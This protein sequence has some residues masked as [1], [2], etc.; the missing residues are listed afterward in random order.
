[1]KVKTIVWAVCAHL[2]FGLLVSCAS[3]REMKKKRSAATRNLGEVYLLKEQYSSA[4]R[5]FLK[6]EKFYA[7]DHILQND[8]GLTLRGMGKLELSLGYF[9]KAI[10]INPEYASAINN[11][12]TVYLAQKNWDAAIDCFKKVT[13]NLL[14]GTPHYPL[15]NL[16]QAYYFK[17]EYKLSEKYYLEALKIEPKFIKALQGLGLTYIAM[18][19]IAD[20]VAI[21]KKAIKYAPRYALLHFDL[22]NAYTLSHEYEKALNSYTQVIELAPESDL[23]EKAAEKIEEIKIL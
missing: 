21:F 12:G 11:M 9:K 22:A 19:R 2:I 4:L 17:K 14:Y 18:D 23:A 6:A 20:A 15:N 8:L 5:E 16:G 1:M 13:E 3:N 7:N 10:K